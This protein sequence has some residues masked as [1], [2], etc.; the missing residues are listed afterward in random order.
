MHVYLG[1]L[2]TVIRYLTFLVCW[3]EKTIFETQFCGAKTPVGLGDQAGCGNASD[4]FQARKN[5]KLER[6]LRRRCSRCCQTPLKC[7]EWG[8][9]W[10][11]TP[12][13]RPGHCWPGTLWRAWFDS[14][15]CQIDC[16]AASTRKK[17]AIHRQQ[18]PFVHIFNYSTYA[19]PPHQDTT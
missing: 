6:A 3:S 7:V 8:V 17:V 11:G 4:L 1:N 14:P 16:S 2:Y 13:S 5:R 19:Y 10:G 15:S 18:A 12:P 9:E